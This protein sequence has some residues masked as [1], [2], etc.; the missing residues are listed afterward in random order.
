MN[1]MKQK[2]LTYLAEHR[3]ELE[4]LARIIWEN[5]EIGLHE[6]FAV[7]EV[8]KVLEKNGFEVQKGVG[9]LPTACIG[10]WGSGKPVIGV[11]GEYDALPGISQKVSAVKEP[12]VEGAPGHGCGHNLFAGGV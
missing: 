9:A 10:S 4:E 7:D 11:L 2:A 12:V 1:E 6:F 5:P 3:D 8:C